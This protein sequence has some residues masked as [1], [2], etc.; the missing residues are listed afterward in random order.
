MIIDN[1]EKGYASITKNRPEEEK[2]NF[3]TESTFIVS[4]GDI[5]RCIYSMSSIENWTECFYGILFTNVETPNRDIYLLMQR[6]TD[7]ELVK[8]KTDA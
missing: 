2:M 7:L 5:V 3:S 4:A 8:V 6:E 1:I